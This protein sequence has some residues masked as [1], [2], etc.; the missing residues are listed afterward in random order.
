MDWRLT[1]S[2]EVLIP[3]ETFGLAIKGRLALS[4]INGRLALSTCMNAGIYH[5]LGHA[6][7]PMMGIISPNQSTLKGAATIGA[8]ATVGRCCSSSEDIP[9]QQPCECYSTA[10]TLEVTLCSKWITRVVSLL[11]CWSLAQDAAEFQQGSHARTAVHGSA[12]QQMPAS[13]H[14]L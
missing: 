8:S 14:T 12:S 10:S 4:T 3:P 6:L 13:R 5:L 9:A 1:A 11:L 2:T 7:A